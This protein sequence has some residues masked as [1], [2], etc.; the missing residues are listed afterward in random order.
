MNRYNYIALEGIDTAG[1]STQFEILKNKLN[2]AIFTKE[3]GGTNI[4]LEIRE[5]VLNG[6]FQSEIATMLMFLA[7]RA[8]H[9]EEVIKPNLDKV[10]VSDRSLIS[11]I[12]YA[13]IANMANKEDNNFSI[14]K[15]L[16]LN[17]LATSHIL[18]TKMILL[19]L[20][21][22]ELQYRLSQ[23]ENDAI[24]SK[25]IDYL[26]NIQDKLEETILKL[27]FINNSKYI[28]IDAKLPKEEIARQIE[29]F[30]NG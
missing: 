25:G 12:A 17:L 5:M 1:K 28:I 21:K 10:I 19:K 30:I 16:E 14:E 20:S 26:I 23:K 11:G 6:R 7:D 2:N 22:E 13:N 18:P 24:E 27:A 9:I 29:E 3:P 4:G 8:E 15:L